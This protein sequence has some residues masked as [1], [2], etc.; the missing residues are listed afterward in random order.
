MEELAS[1]TQCLGCQGKRVFQ[2][3]RKGQ[4]G[5]PTKV[6]TDQ[7]RGGRGGEAAE[8]GRDE[9]SSRKRFSLRGNITKDN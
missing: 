3:G 9:E 7:A 5:D 1:T 6:G 2:D 8:R 4:P